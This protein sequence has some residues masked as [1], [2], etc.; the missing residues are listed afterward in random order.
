[1][2]VAVAPSSFGPL[3]QFFDNNGVPLAG[4]QLFTYAAGT[5]T[6]LATYTDETGSTANTTPVIL[7]AA[8][9]PTSGG[10]WVAIN[11]AYKFVLSPATDTN[12]PTNAIWTVDNMTVASPNTFT[13]DAGSGGES[14][15][16]PAPPSGSFAAG[17]YLSAGGSW[18]GLL[19]TLGASIATNQAGFLGAPYN[20]QNASYQLQLSDSGALISN[21]S[22]S[23]ITIAIPADATVSWPAGQATIIELFAAQGLGSITIAPALGVSLYGPPGFTS[24]GFRVLAA[25]GQAV[26]TRMGANYWTIVGAG[27]S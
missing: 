18:L 12:P 14:G 16:V 21:T 15:V 10:L 5:T 1:M 8:G 20:P 22:A 24:S 17:D 25:N 27:I 19:V 13:G 3:P 11:T 9:R 7:N 23:P 2:T 6:P 4:G 26:L